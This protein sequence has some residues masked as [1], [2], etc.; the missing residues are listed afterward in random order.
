[1]LRAPLRAGLSAK[2]SESRTLVTP[3]DLPH[4]RPPGD[5][6]HPPPATGD[7]LRTEWGAPART[8]G[9]RIGLAPY[10]LALFLQPPTRL[11]IDSRATRRLLT[12]RP[13]GPARFWSAL[14]RLAAAPW[15]AEWHARSGAGA[16]LAAGG[17]VAQKVRRRPPGEARKEIRKLAN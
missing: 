5:R 16:S 3:A 15:P 12:A 9:P 10:L 11:L 4:W 8:A 2:R 1:M 17:G 13:S 7:T 14:R 6:A